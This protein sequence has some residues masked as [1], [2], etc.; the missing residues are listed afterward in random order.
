MAIPRNDT[1][2]MVWLNNFSEKIGKYATTLGLTPADV[3]SVQDD[4]AMLTYLV[5]GFLPAYKAGLQSCTAYKNLMLNGPLGAPGGDLP[6]PPDAG[7]PP[8]PVTPGVIPRMR[9]LLQRIQGST[10]YTEAI[11]EDLNITTEESS[12]AVDTSSA[13]PTARAVS[14]PQSEVRIEFDK[15]KFDGVVI[16]ARHTGEKDWSRLATDNYSP[17]L[18]TRAPATPGQPEVREYRLRYILRDEEVGEWSDIIS[19][20]TTP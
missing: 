5:G 17:Y 15:R 14:L 9:K 2:L 16:E 6:A 10:N 7:T 13:K 3:T 8:K 18:D 11:G 20:T 1:D 19:A 4:A 12:A